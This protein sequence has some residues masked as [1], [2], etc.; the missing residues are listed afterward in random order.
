[1]EFVSIEKLLI[2]TKLLPVGPVAEIVTALENMIVDFDMSV[3]SVIIDV[4]PRATRNMK[5]WGNSAC[6]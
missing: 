1:V 5:S 3:I 4:A 2:S 6:Y